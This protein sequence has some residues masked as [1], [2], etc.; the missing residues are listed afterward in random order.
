[1]LKV[2]YEIKVQNHY[3]LPKLRGSCRLVVE[4]YMGGEIGQRAKVR[5]DILL[6]MVVAKSSY[7]Q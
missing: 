5:H 4:L 1:M 2:A 3:L 7:L 6:C